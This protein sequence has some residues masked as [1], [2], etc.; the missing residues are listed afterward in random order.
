MQQS[1][2]NKPHTERQSRCAAIPCELRGGSL[3]PVLVEK[4]LLAAA[5]PDFLLANESSCCRGC[6]KLDRLD[7]L[8][9][10]LMDMCMCMGEL[11]AAAAMLP[12]V[13]AAP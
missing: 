9:R 7:G 5:S 6:L 2:A 1:W 10:V 12:F 3:P 13:D 8:A 4:L 11:P